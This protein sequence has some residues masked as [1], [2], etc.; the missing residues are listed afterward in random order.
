MHPYISVIR[1]KVI[2]EIMHLMNYCSLLFYGN[3][4]FIAFC[5][6]PFF[7]VNAFSLVSSH[8]FAKEPSA[9]YSTSIIPSHACTLLKNSI[10][11]HSN[12]PSLQCASPSLQTMILWLCTLPGMFGKAQTGET[13]ESPPSWASRTDALTTS[14]PS[15]EE[16]SRPGRPTASRSQMTPSHHTGRRVRADSPVVTHR[17]TDDDSAWM[18]SEM[19]SMESVEIAVSVMFYKVA[20]QYHSCTD[21]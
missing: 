18:W 9:F 4:C 12:Y 20:D 10:W 15:V 1:G 14:A 11:E 7:I 19:I 16:A 3:R 8:F 2:N 13:A 21:T 5:I 17:T 6:I